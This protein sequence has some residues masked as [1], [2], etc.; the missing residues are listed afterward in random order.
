MPTPPG[1]SSEPV[2]PRGTAI[3]RQRR[4]EDR[5]RSYI[6]TARQLAKRDLIFI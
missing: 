4:R 6:G 3:C 2:I 1:L 5:L